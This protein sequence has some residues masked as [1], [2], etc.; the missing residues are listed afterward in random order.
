M[1]PRPWSPIRHVEV[2]INYYES[3]CRCCSISNRRSDRLQY[4]G[5]EFCITGYAAFCF[6]VSLDLYAITYS[7]LIDP[8]SEV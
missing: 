8:E 3:D 7:D 4:R 1:D 2:Y 5:P 6:R